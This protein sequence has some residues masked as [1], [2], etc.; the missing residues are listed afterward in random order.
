MGAG[1]QRFRRGP[2]WASPPRSLFPLAVGRATLA[3]CRAAYER[4]SARA[5]ADLTVYLDAALVALAAG[6][7]PAAIRAGAPSPSAS[8]SRSAS[9]SP[10]ASLTPTV[11][12][13][14]SESRA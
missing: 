14:R 4:W 11:S 9:P 13:S 8:P 6:F 7:D 3:A 1:D 10:S 2:A 12:P 5:D